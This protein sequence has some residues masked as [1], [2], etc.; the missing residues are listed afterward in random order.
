MKRIRY[1]KYVP[2][3][4]ADMSMEDLLSAL[5]DYFL[6]SGF[7]DNFWYELPEREQTLDELKS[8]LEQALLN[9]EMFDEEMRDRLQQMQMDGELEELIEK[10]IE[11]MQQ[12]DYISIDQPH[13]PAKQSSVGGQVGDAQQQA[14]FE[15]TD[16]S[17]D[18]LGFKALR[19]L[20]GSLGKSSFGR[21]DTRDMATGIEA[22]GAS[23][24]YEF[25]DTLN[26][27]ITATLSSAIQREGLGLPLNLEYRDLQVHQ[28]EYQSSCATVLM[29]DCSHSMILYGEDRFT[30]AKKVA[31]ALSQ[32]IRTQYPG[33]SLSLVLFHDSAE[34]VPL[35]QLARV[36]VGP[37]YTNTR[38]GLRMAQRILQRQR[39]DMKQIVMITDG[40]PSALTLED[41]RIYK[42][43]FGLD[44]LVV[45]Q[46][47][48]EVS[49][50]KRA[51]V[52]INTFMLAS[53][54]GLVQFVQKVTQMCRGKA[55]FTTPYT[56]GQYLLMDYM[57][58][59]TKTIH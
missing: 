44:P 50:C 58:R 39:K 52:L 8:A 13:D 34:E 56:L 33:D 54:Y 23:K 53:D 11:R 55:Y 42:N 6:Q 2:D 57:S 45:S 10:L 36:K 19:D 18:F 40:K 41:G 16:K 51:G 9:G 3:P 26:L 22:S 47:L 17:L 46:T 31:M 35:S 29:L 25:G 28:C 43:A 37:Y 5:S 1:S 59:K 7:N 32:L 14:K 24:Q 38:E 48:E 49:K 27:D 15:I 4:A 20:L 21:H 12:E 30:P